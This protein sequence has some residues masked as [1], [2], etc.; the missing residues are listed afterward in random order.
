MLP[1]NQLVLAGIIWLLADANIHI[2]RKKI[3]S[4]IIKALKTLFIF[5]HYK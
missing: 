3:N 5:F 4:T 1:K 2:K